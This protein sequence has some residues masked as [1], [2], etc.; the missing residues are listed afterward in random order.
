VTPHVEGLGHAVPDAECGRRW[1]YRELDL[2]L[3]AGTVTVIV[4]PNGAGKSTLLR[5]LAGLSAPDEGHALLGESAIFTMVPRERARRIAY[6][7]QITPLYHD[8]RVGELVMLGRAPHLGRFQTPGERDRALVDA[9]LDTVGLRGLARRGVFSLS[10]GEYQ[11]VMLA[12][13]LATDSPVLLLDEPTAA[14]DIGHALGFLELCRRLAGEGRS[15]AVAMHDLELARR[16]ADAA[17]CLRNEPD[18]ATSGGP[19]GE[20]LTPEILA[21][22]FGVTIRSGPEGLVF[23]PGATA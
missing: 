8:L 16:Y 17:V 18:G 7:P 20:V 15:L 14:L 22:V 5:D 23:S 2:S 10:G 21:P 19:A 12:R 11:R 1:L 13:M 6:L 4:G 9:A 3:A